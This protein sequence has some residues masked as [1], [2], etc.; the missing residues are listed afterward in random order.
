[1]YI[2][3]N[4][5][6]N[7][8]RSK[9]RSC[10]IG[11]I[12]FILALSSC[13]GLSIQQA[14]KTS[15]EASMELTNIT[16]QIQINR[17]YLMNQ[18]RENT[19]SENGKEMMKEAL[20]S[21]QSLSLDELQTYANSS[22]V[23]NFYYTGSLSLNGND[24]LEA[25]TSQTSPPNGM[26]GGK[27]ANMSSGDFTVTGYSSDDAMT[28]FIDGTNSIVE[29]TMFV[30]ATSDATAII[31]SELASLND[32]SVNDTIT[33][34]DP[35]DEDIT[36]PVK[37]IGIYTSSAS[38]T[39]SQMPNGMNS[40]DSANQIYMSYASLQSIAD[41]HNYSLRTSGTYVFQTVEDY[42][43][44]ETDCRN[45]GLDESY[46][47]TS[48]DVTSYEQSL[49]PL[50]NLSTYALY[51]VIVVLAIGGIVLFVLNIFSIRERKYEIGILCAIGMKKIKVASQFLC[52]MFIIA[53]V[54]VLLGV[55]I[56]ALTSV[57]VTN[58]LLENQIQSSQST[59]QRMEQNFL[60]PDAGNE[61]KDSG[62]DMK[63][64]SKAMQRPG[65]SNI[66][67]VTTVS[68]AMNVQVLIQ[69]IGLTFLLVVI[70]STAGLVFIM[71]YDPLMIL[72]NRD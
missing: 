36:I 16:A 34:T 11:I 10:L 20:G 31:S 6:R 8:W 41:E 45:K 4:A 25:V 7:I 60:R 3:K 46:S 71:R 52:E 61:Q 58:A 19:P 18:A 13:I 22:Y 49:L 17:E 39:T 40:M 62:N 27:G 68:E 35:D 26:Q 66:S 44:F 43:N 70:S 69:M 21:M 64:Q 14:A 50:E 63:G 59:N 9:A 2:I 5:L 55:S 67:Y 51:F 37:V 65:T 53:G 30:E 57:P 72:T 54:A 29:G 38:T 28:T 23:K 47:V 48:N 15:K 42:E 24:Q 33:F 12:L 32:I 56:G 1:M